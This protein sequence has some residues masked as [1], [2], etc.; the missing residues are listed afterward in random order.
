MIEENYDM[1]YNIALSIL[2]TILVV[3]ILMAIIEYLVALLSKN[4]KYGL[5][6]YKHLGPP[7]R[8][9]KCYYYFYVSKCQLNAKVADL[10]GTHTLKKTY[11]D[12]D[13]K[14]YVAVFRK[15]TVK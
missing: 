14:S 6:D 8:Y 13:V 15:K 9:S 1:P 12:K 4:K 3:L 2:I 11:Y 7:P 10:E 5:P